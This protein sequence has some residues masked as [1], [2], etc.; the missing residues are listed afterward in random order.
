MEN[1]L[2]T[3]DLIYK[4][5]NKK[6]DKTYVFQKFKAI[7]SSGRKVYN[8]YLSLDDALEQQGRLQ[9]NTDIFKEPTKLKESVKK[10]KK[11]LTLKSAIILLNG[12]QEALNA[13]ESGIFPKGKQGKGPISVLDFVACIESCPT[14][15]SLTVSSWYTNMN[16]YTPKQIFERL[17]IAL[18]Q[19]KA[20]N[21]SENLLNEI[22][23]IIYSLYWAKEITKKV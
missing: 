13:F 7:R 15:R 8:N 19:V 11:T 17:T 20:D 9:D 22:R 6:K 14:V 18:A 23:Q 3:A 12:R 2:N 5:G 16:I 10:W 21:T 4:T 1:K